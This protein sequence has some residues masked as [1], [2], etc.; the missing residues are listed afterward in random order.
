MRKYS[1]RR[2][3][4]RWLAGAP[5]YV[6]DCFDNPQFADRYTIWFGKSEA[7]HTRRDGS[8]GQGPDQYHNTY[9]TGL[10]TSENGGV[11]GALEYSAHDVAKYRYANKHRRIR[12]QDLPESTR[13]MVTRLVESDA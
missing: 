4:Q 3:S 12:W 5:E 7:F 13:K 1:P 6:L 8:I 11:S 10:G 2:A 9:I